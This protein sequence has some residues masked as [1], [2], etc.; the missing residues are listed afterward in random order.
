MSRG[1]SFENMV[2]D[3][4]RRSVVNSSV[5]DSLEAFSVYS[6]LGLNCRKEIIA[7]IRK[8][9]LPFIPLIANR[10]LEETG[11]GNFKDKLLKLYFSI[12]NTPGVEDLMPQVETGDEGMSLYEYSAYGV[13]CALQPATNPC[14]TLINNSIAMLASGNSV[15]HI[16]SPRCIGVSGFVSDKINK[17]IY[18]VCGIKN[19]VITLSEVS[20][21]ITDEII[22][23]PD[24]SLVVATGGEKTVSRA[25]K[26]PKRVIGAGQ[27]N[28]VVIVDETAD[29][30]K[31][32]RDIVTGA[33]FDNNIT[34]ITEKNIVAVSE[35]APR[36]I[37]ELQKQG[38]YYVDD[39]AKMLK[40]SKVCL[41]EDL[42]MN[43][44]LE[45]KSADEILKAAGIDSAGNIRLIVVNTM[46]KH[47]F[48]IEE[49]MMPLVPLIVTKDFKEA[50]ETSLFIEQG[51]RHTAMIHSQ[52]ISRLNE[53]AHIMQ[54]SV[55][56]KNGPSL[57]ALGFFGEEKACFTLANVT[58]EGVVTARN[59]ARKRRCSL[60]SGFSIK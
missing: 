49:M 27:A 57:I 43:R 55:F 7:K 51:F 18:D 45:G 14:A 23:H 1:G 39:K 19:L 46:K 38:V 35:V 52:S 36:L 53:A 60:T 13:I 12:K 54:T 24:V 2:K 28:P 48:A 56:I 20:K 3:D 42:K 5:L 21:E 16:P 44:A 6:G 33:S 32:A 50:L 58:G 15:I 41:N 30:S 47:P 34:C 37:G 59:F 9:L 17:I 11:M 31:A 22:S 8:E 4:M 26:A 29:V 25:L 40:L 10:E